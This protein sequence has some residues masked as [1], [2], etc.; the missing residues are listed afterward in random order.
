MSGRVQMYITGLG[1]RRNCSVLDGSP[2]NYVPCTCLEMLLPAAFALSVLS[3]CPSSLQSNFLAG[4]RS[5]KDRRAQTQKQ[6]RR[7][8]AAT[9]QA[10]LLISAARSPAG[11]FNCHPD[12][13]RWVTCSLALEISNMWDNGL[14]SC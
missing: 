14:F 5:G 13:S 9:D 4:R 3:D 7:V 10:R 6:Q 1:N 2:S 12:E 11:C 8:C